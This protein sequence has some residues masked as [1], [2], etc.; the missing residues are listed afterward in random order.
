GV[1]GG[2]VATRQVDGLALQVEHAVAGNHPEI[3]VGVARLEL[4]QPGE[5]PERREAAGGG[6]GHRAGVDRPERLDGLA[7]LIEPGV[8]GAKEPRALWSQLEAAVLPDEER[9]AQR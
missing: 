6:D 2:A 7:E 1:L 3:H 5:E 9:A 4:R 8:G